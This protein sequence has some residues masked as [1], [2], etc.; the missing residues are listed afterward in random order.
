[1]KLQN[2]KEIFSS[3]PPFSHSL[4][5]S[6]SLGLKSLCCETAVGIKS[7]Y[8]RESSGNY[9]FSV[10]RIA[11]IHEE[12]NKEFKLGECLRL[13]SLAFRVFPLA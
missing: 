3:L 9:N 1:V 4:S 2:R 11:G 12:D 6:L 8:V 10:C 7:V 5:L 13:F